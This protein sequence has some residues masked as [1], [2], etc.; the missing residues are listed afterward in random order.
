MAWQSPSA[1]SS[2]LSPATDSGLVLVFFVV[3]RQR[4]GGID[5]AHWHFVFVP[6]LVVIFHHAC[7]LRLKLFD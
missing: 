2:P 1:S 6:I 4:N 7:K 5:G 3:G